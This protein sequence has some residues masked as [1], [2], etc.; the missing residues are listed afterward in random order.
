MVPSS[1]TIVFLALYGETT[2]WGSWSNLWLGLAV[3]C[4]I[5]GLLNLV[6]YAYAHAGQVVMEARLAMSNTPEVRMFEAA[7]GMHPEAVRLLLTQRKTVWRVRYVPVEDMVDWV[8]DEA[9]SVH[10]GFV[11]FVLNNSNADGLMPKNLLSEGAYTFDPDKKVLDRDQYQDL[12]TLLQAKM[13]VTQA[14]GNQSARWIAPWEP[15]TVR[16][17]MGIE[18]GDSEAELNTEAELRESGYGGEG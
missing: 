2:D 10:V 4:A 5:A 7:R 16:R 11:E 18:E 15:E 17:R 6:L 9:P 1:L 8:L 12:V 3:I 14:F 13:M